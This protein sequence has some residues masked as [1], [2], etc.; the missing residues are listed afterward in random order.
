MALREQIDNLPDDFNLEELTEADKNIL[1]QKLARNN[2]A[3][4]RT[5]ISLKRQANTLPNDNAITL[6]D[7]ENWSDYLRSQNA[8]RQAEESLRTHFADVLTRTHQAP[9]AASMFKALTRL[10]QA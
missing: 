3:L 4:T 10:G 8:V 7:P 6:L 5:V 9:W 1:L 2:L